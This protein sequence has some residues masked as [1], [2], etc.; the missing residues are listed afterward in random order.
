LLIS[1]VIAAVRTRQPDAA[2]PMFHNPL[3]LLLLVALPAVAWL[4]R[5]RG[6]PALVIPGAE[7]W[8]APG[9]TVAAWWPLAC[10]YLGIALLIGALARPQVL[11][12]QEDNKRRGYDFMIAI[13][14]STSMYAE[15][16]KR[17]TQTTNRLQAIKPVISAFINDRPNDRIGIVVFG[18]RAYTFA[19]LTFD[20]D[21]LRKQS[22]RLAIG[23]IEDGTAIGD[24]LGICLS[25][26]KEGAKDKSVPR[27]GGFIVLL[28]D[29]ASNKG[30]I[31]PRQA[32]TLA[33]QDNVP[34]YTIGAG[35]EGNI[36]M[37][38]FDAA[39]RRVGTEMQASEVDTLM[40]QDISTKT[41][42]KFFRAT[43]SNA[44]REAFAEIDDAQKIEFGAPPPMISRELFPAFTWAGVILLALALYGT[45]LRPFQLQTRTFP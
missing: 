23:L 43:N 4:R 14:L 20:H 22:S 33:A 1:T 11:V 8:H 29:G 18:G 39:G 3:W 32:A 19:P 40:L 21:W 42:G 9:P 2:V 28:T 35:A 45:H 38:V 12:P 31:D 37:P 13:D 17:G 41:G 16:F 36:P 24:A 27:E 6:V 10:A 44:V 30:S 34:I 5:R 26:L 7:Q 25:R 15:D